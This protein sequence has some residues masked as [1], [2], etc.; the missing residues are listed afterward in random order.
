MKTLLRIL[1]PIVSLALLF[2]ALAPLFAIIYAAATFGPSFWRG[3]II[4]LSAEWYRFIQNRKEGWVD[5]MIPKSREQLE[6][7]HFEGGLRRA[8][9]AAYHGRN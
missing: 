1:K 3:V 9:E 2:V 7:E 4:G 8:L 6:R 5:R